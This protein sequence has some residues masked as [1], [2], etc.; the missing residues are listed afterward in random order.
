[1]PRIDSAE[2]ALKGLISGFVRSSLA[3]CITHETTDG[4]LVPFTGVDEIGLQDLSYVLTK[5]GRVKVGIEIYPE[6]AAAR[7]KR[8]GPEPPPCRNDVGLQEGGKVPLKAGELPIAVEPED[9]RRGRCLRD[10][11]NLVAKAHRT[12]EPVI[13]VCAR[14]ALQRY[15]L[16]KMHHGGLHVAGQLESEWI[17]VDKACVIPWRG[18][19]K[20]VAVQHVERDARSK[21]LAGRGKQP[22]TAVDGIRHLPGKVRDVL[23]GVDGR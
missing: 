17:V 12:R 20:P 8:D 10:D 3:E 22:E 21:L 14:P 16:A 11:D 18:D 4:G 15:G 7:V 19:A 23:G 1:M 6:G 5:G 13:V 2:S 9:G